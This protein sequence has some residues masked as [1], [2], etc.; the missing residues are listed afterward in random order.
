[1]TSLE[2]LN[3]S[4]LCIG[5]R[6]NS[7]D[8]LLAGDFNIPNINWCDDTISDYPSCMQSARKLLE[9]ASDH[10]LD[11]F[12]LEP[13][14]RQGKVANILDL[15]FTNKAS[16]IQDTQVIPGISDH[17]MVITD[18]SLEPPRRRPQK[19]KVYIRKRANVQQIKSDLLSFANYYLTNLLHAD[20][21]MK[22]DTFVATISD[23]LERNVPHKFTSCRTNL[24]WFNRDHCHM[25]RKK[26]RLYNKPKDQVNLRTGLH[27]KVSGDH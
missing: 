27:L 20:L 12:V 1:M 13:T 4:L 7:H 22:W 15:V 3:I 6:M 10:N 2:S 16:L 9:I 25:C 8:V 26:Q 23:T 17:D 18:L 5:Q 14:R 19:R 21:D 11:Q 24:P